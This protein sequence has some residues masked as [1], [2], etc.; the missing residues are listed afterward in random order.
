MNPHHFGRVKFVDDSSDGTVIYKI[1]DGEQPIEIHQKD[2]INS[3]HYHGFLDQRFTDTKLSQN[4]FRREI[5]HDTLYIQDGEVIVTEKQLPAKPFKVHKVEE[6]ISA[7]DTF[8]TFD[9]ET[10]NVSGNHH[11]YLITA[12]YGHYTGGNYINSIATNITEEAQATM[13][14]SFLDQLLNLKSIKYAYAHNLSGFDEILLLKHL[15]NYPGATVKPLLF[16]G[17][18]MAIRF[19]VN[20]RTI[21]FKDS[22]L[23]LPMGLRRLCKSFNVP[24]VKTHFPFYFSDI[25]YSGDFPAYELFTDLSRADYE[26]L[27]STLR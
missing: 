9:I 10:V 17:K 6:K 8:C 20:N 18:L 5:N 4:I 11:P 23:L 13:F 2:N 1:F 21:I 26:Q 14:I 15:L 27:F 12:Y 22:F 24:T 25:N 7:L 16:N 19:K 3:V